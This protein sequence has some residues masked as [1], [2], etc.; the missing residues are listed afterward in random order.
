MDRRQDSERG[1]LKVVTSR[2]SVRTISMPTRAA[3]P[4]QRPPTGEPGGARR[5]TLVLGLRTR[6][7]PTQGT[8]GHSPS[9][10]SDLHAQ[11]TIALN[12]KLQD[13]SLSAIE[14]AQ[15]LA[16]SCFC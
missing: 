3:R 14:A 15:V 7:A 1:Q 11:R 5:L 6:V 13:A 4:H 10:R 8:D 12:M 16:D 9:E 2:R